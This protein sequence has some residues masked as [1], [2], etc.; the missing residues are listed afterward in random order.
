[1]TEQK[2]PLGVDEPD[3][4]EPRITTEDAKARV[5]RMLAPKVTEES[6]KRKIKDVRYGSVGP[7]GTMCTIMMRNGF[8]VVGFSAS[9]SVENFDE[10]VGRRYA[11]DNALKQLWPLEG[12]LL[13]SILAGE[14]SL[15]EPPA[16]EAM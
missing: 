14:V 1:M 3:T 9:A 5:A 11:Y 10:E 7:S 16:P 6:I 4:H 12:Y 2:P 8:Q 15:P 13:R